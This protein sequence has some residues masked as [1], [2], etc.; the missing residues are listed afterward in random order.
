MT[1]ATTT[2]PLSTR[3]REVLELLADGLP[4]R[5]IAERLGIAET[6]ARN[7]IHA[8]LHRLGCHSQLQAVAVA[9]RMHLIA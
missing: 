9:R 5:L 6:T 8:L 4:A 1:D 7:H 3:Q 2:T